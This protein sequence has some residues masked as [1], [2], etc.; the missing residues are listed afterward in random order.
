MSSRAHVFH[1]GDTRIYEV[2]GN[3]LEQVTSDHRLRIS[4]EQ[5]YLGRA[6]GIDT[7]L[8][9][10]YS[11]V[12]LEEGNIFLLATDGVYEHVA[13]EFI[14]STVKGC[15]DDLDRAARLIVEEALQRGSKDNL[16][17]QVVRIDALPDPGAGAI[18]R[19]LAQLPFPPLLEARA[20][21]DGYKI[22]R[23]L[24]GSS[25]SHIYLAVD[26]ETDAVVVLKTPSVD[27]Q[28]DTAY[29]ERFLM[30][31]WVTRRINSAHV[32]KP[33]LQTRKRNFLYAVMEFVEG[34]TLAQWMEAERM[35]S[36]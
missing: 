22:V 30:E 5:S 26:I 13:P 17:C 32:L 25:R 12:D 28:D 33:C 19:Q 3:A 20:I 2:H 9:I 8:E 31:E 15:R 6:L 27:L 34:Q 10:D 23:E 4:A 18:Y 1:V 29:L 21:F 16:T 11:T 14:L 7:H 35:V 24:H 36:E